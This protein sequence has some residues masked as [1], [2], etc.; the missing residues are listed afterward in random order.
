MRVFA[1]AWLQQTP[2]AAGVCA[3]ALTLTQRQRCRREVSTQT[4]CQSVNTLLGASCTWSSGFPSAS[5]L[6]ITPML[7]V[8]L[9]SAPSLVVVTEKTSATTVVTT[10]FM[11]PRKGRWSMVVVVAFLCKDDRTGDSAVSTP[12]KRPPADAGLHIAGEVTLGLCFCADCSL[13]RG[14]SANGPFAIGSCGICCSGEF[15]AR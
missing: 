2:V 1:A 8:G 15:Q 11:P 3:H 13:Q 12:R 5:T 10:A 9:P 4:H 6:Q 7:L 14:R